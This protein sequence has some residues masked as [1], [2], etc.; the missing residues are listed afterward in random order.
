MGT[1]VTMHCS[2]KNGGLCNIMSALVG[3]EAVDVV[4]VG[5]GDQEWLYFTMRIYTR[6]A[7][8]SVSMNIS[9]FLYFYA[10]IWHSMIFSPTHAF[11]LHKNQD[12]DIF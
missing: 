9:I 7:F 4:K 12:I 8:C 10:S 11:L 6:H 1:T 5:K 2:D 3:R